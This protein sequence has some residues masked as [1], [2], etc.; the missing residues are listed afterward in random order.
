VAAVA[1]QRFP[2]ASITLVAARATE[3]SP[4]DDLTAVEPWDEVSAF[5]SLAPVVPDSRA[6]LTTAEAVVRSWFI[7]L[8]TSHPCLVFE[9][10]YRPCP[11]S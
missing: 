6:W 2:S 5:F 8:V 10:V 7:D 11:E 9:L 1:Q 4:T 3:A